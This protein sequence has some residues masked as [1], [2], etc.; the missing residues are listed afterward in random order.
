MLIIYIKI[1]IIIYSYS[2]SLNK[3]YSTNEYE[4]K[5][6][7]FKIHTIRMVNKNSEKCFINFF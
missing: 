4:C 7:S 5:I 1:V 6:L 2:F 3:V